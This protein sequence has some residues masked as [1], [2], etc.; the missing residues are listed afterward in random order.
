MGESGPAVQEM[1]L[2]AFEGRGQE[3]EVNALDAGED[4]GLGRVVLVREQVGGLVEGHDL[5]AVV[6]LADRG[7]GR[8]RVSGRRVCV[9]TILPTGGAGVGSG[10]WRR[11][12]GIKDTVAVVGEAPFLEAVFDLD[13]EPFPWPGGR[14]VDELETLKVIH[15]WA[16]P[17]EVLMDVNDYCIRVYRIG[18]RVNRVLCSNRRREY[19]GWKD[20]MH[21]LH[22]KETCFAFFFFTRRPHSRAE[23]C[24]DNVTKSIFL[25]CAQAC[26][27]PVHHVVSKMYPSLLVNEEGRRGGAGLDKHL[28]GLIDKRRLVI[29]TA[30]GTGNGY[31]GDMQRSC[32]QWYQ[33]YGVCCAHSRL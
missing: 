20:K 18:G 7:R 14:V 4:A 13:D 3:V 27:L 29:N 32:L 8:S 21:E 16:C 17:L 24:K 33:G 23:A 26:V 1:V 5:F 2:D 11:M 19:E 9:V 6:E 25:I 12:G 30:V 10:G 31:L 22:E 28:F 15:P